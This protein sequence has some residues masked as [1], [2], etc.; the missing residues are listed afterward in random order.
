MWSVGVLFG[1]GNRCNIALSSSR[2]GVDVHLPSFHPNSPNVSGVFSDGFCSACGFMVGARIDLAVFV[3]SFAWMF[4]LSSVIS[5]LLFGKQRRV[6]IQFLIS[7]A[8]TVTSTVLFDALKSSGFDLTNP[9]NVLSNS[10]TQFFGNAFF[11]F[12]YL[13]LPYIFM[14]VIDLRAM[15]KEVKYKK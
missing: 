4:V 10:Y 14:L 5:N 12:F 6:F 15:S 3:C 2:V 13:S 11:A 8:L 1:K 9:N 7:L